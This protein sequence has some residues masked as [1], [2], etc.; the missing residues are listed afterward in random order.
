MPRTSPRPIPPPWDRIFPLATRVFVWALL[1]GILYLLRSFFLLIFLTFVFAYLQAHGVHWLEKFI[2]L[3][4]I[5]V[6]L[7][8]L[9][10]LGAIVGAGF[11]VV[12]NVQREVNLVIENRE[13]HFAEVDG[14]IAWLAHKF[15]Q[16][17]GVLPEIDP[18]SPP[19]TTSQTVIKQILGLGE[20]QDGNQKLKQA[21]EIGKNVSVYLF[22]IISAFLLSLLFSFLIVLSLPDLTRL[23]KKLGTT[24]VAFIYDEVHQNITDFATVLG[25]SLEAQSLV[26][27]LNTVLT[28]VGIYFMGLPSIAFLSTIVF[29]FSFVPIAGVFLS[30]VPIC[31]IALS[32]GGLSWML[33]AILLITIIHLVE[34]YVLNPIIYGHHLKVNSVLVLSVLTV[35]GTLFHVWGLVLGLPVMIYVFAHAIRY[36]PGEEPDREPPG[37]LP[38]SKG[39]P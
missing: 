15:P 38:F 24:K 10:F 7:V 23:V 28:A 5:R 12:P 21:V 25:R 4:Q 9:A 8:A 33:L 35:A 16:L 29:F 27:V 2:K 32:E 26:A 39:T 13:K 19:G 17:K 37:T 14:G 30:S 22:G 3:R 34:T 36:K 18:N 1:A 20:V 11:W 31:L 6:V